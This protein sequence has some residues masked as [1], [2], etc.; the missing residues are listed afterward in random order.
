MSAIHAP[1]MSPAKPESGPT[2][3]ERQL[4]WAAIFVSLAVFWY[5]FVNGLMTLW[6][7]IAG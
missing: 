4:T 2:A 6:D 5:G 7:V 3:T 1:G